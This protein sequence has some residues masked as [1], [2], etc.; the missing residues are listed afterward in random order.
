MIKKVLIANRGE[1][2]MR[3]IRAC[4]ELNMETVSV[5]SKADDSSLHK[6]FAD[7]SIC[8]GEAKAEDSY[9]SI[10]RIIAAA[11]I[12]GA[13]AIHP[14]YGFLSENPNLAS[15]CE[16]NN[17]KFIGPTAEVIRLMG[18]KNTA[19]ETVKKIKIPLLPG[20]GLL[21]NIEDAKAQAKKMKYPVILKATAGGGGRGMRVCNNWQDLS[22]N[23][24]L[25]KSEAGI[26]FGN[27]GIYMEQ[28]IRKPRHVEVQILA[29]SFGNVIHLGERDC[30]VQR[31][32]QK[33]IEETPSPFINKSV[34]KK[35]CA[36]AIDIAKEI[37]Y[38]GVGTVEFLVDEDMRFYFM[39]MNTRIQVEHTISEL[40]TGIDLV[41]EQI[42]VANGSKI[43]YKQSDVIFRGHVIECRINAE[44]PYNNFAPSPGKIDRFHV[45]QGLGVRIDSHIYAGYTVPPNYDSMIAKL[46]VWGLD[47]D[48][49]I[50]RM[51]RSLDEMIVDGVK[52]NLPF[53]DYFI[54][55]EIFKHL[56]FDTNY[57]N[58]F[59]LMPDAST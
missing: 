36:S 4:K 35:I 52:T 16:A 53:H 25:T 24:D 30:S 46:I 45:P 39:E 18:D 32:H 44:D 55:S 11:E 28:F 42:R 15:A 20:T 9:L 10:P 5:Y 34:R 22:K 47:R 26:N 13:D 57:L 50:E 27:D 3:I 40:Y 14:G 33:I 6:N 38:A 49:A 23:F 59:R 58:N 21:E 1:I 29:D 43:R 56:E 12:S 2:A 41:K 31:R 51:R 17:I 19:R 48:E 37:K 8:I 54:S 7:E